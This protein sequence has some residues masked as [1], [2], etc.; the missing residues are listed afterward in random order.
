[1]SDIRSPTTENPSILI[2]VNPAIEDYLRGLVAP[3]DHPVLLEMEKLARLEN[4]PIVD[5]LVGVFLATQA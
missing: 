1:M 3:T 4:F 5:R 2:P